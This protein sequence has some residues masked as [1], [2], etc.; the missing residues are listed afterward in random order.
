MKLTDRV[1][2]DV[3]LPR[4]QAVN[5][6]HNAFVGM[7]ESVFD[8]RVVAND[9]V[10]YFVYGQGFVGEC[11]QIYAAPAH[12]IDLHEALRL[13]AESVEDGARSRLEDADETLSFDVSVEDSDDAPGVRVAVSE[14]AVDVPY[15]WTLTEL[16]QAEYDGWERLGRPERRKRT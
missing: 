6:L 1:H 5:V 12:G 15:A 13:F 3:D 16:P 9:A 7:V 11:R 10:A 2:I 4:K 14:F 8:D